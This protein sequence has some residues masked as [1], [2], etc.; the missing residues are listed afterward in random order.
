MESKKH[1]YTPA[2]YLRR[3]C[4]AQGKVHVIK[5][6]NGKIARSWRGPDHIGFEYHLYSYHQDFVANDR[7]EI[8]TKFFSPLD[9]EG[10]RIVGEMLAG[11]VLTQKDKIRWTQFLLSM[12]VRAP[13][14]VEKIKAAGEE[15]IAREMRDAQSDYAKLRQDSDPETP[16]DWL[17]KY[18]PGLMESFGTG[19][20]PKIASNPRAMQDVLS[21]SWHVVD[22]TESAIA[23][24]SSDR[25]CVYTEGLHKPDCVIALPLSP[26]SAFFAF[27]SGSKAERVLMK[28]PVSRLASGLNESVV[29]QAITRAFSQQANDAPDAFFKRRLRSF[30]GPQ[31]RV[32]RT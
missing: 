31:D 12:R 21:F 1:H 19:Q 20:L 9:N 7:A 32:A 15:A 11:K 27:R 10:A 18:R 26:K 6:L 17:R 28:T 13:E 3:W 5:N 4:G 24:L 8:E 25:P 30:E 29:G 23:L 2:F 16:L 22:F 14:N